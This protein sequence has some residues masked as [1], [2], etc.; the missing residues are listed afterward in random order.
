[1]RI[2]MQN[3]ELREYCEYRELVIDYSEHSDVFVDS[4]RK[5]KGISEHSDV[6]VDSDRK[7]KGISEHSDVFV[8]SDRINK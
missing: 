7:H 8:V 2:I 5:H 6:F 4:D 1:M 3:Y